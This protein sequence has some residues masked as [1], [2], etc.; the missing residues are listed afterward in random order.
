MR[1]KY[2]G[3]EMILD[4]VDKNFDGNQD[5]YWICNKCHSSCFEKIRY[6]K[7]VG[8]AFEPSENARHK[9]ERVDNLMYNGCEPHWHCKHCDQYT[10]FHCYSKEELETQLLC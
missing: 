4:D 10:P 7:S 6:N 2:C 1:C 9:V 8:K 5:N 3:S